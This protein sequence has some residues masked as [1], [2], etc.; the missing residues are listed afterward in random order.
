MDHVKV[1]DVLALQRR[2]VTVDPDTE[3]EE[4]GVRSF[5]K[6]IFHKSPVTGLELGNKRVFRIEPV[7]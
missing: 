3:Y 1:G 7:T 2:A 5:G 6:G 4:I